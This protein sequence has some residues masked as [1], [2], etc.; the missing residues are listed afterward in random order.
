FAQKR[1]GRDHIQDLVDA[2]H[3]RQVQRLGLLGIVQSLSLGTDPQA[4]RLP[5]DLRLDVRRGLHDLD[6]LVALVRSGDD[7]IGQNHAP[8]PRT[9]DAITSAI[10]PPAS[11]DSAAASA[12][13][14]STSGPK[15]PLSISRRVAEYR[16]GFR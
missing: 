11:P 16:C 12:S 7:R 8:A 10:S 1:I 14:A 3:L 5:T 6:G 4:L 13:W 15:H 9:A 2:D